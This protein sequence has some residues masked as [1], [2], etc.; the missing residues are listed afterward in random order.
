MDA[1]VCGVEPFAWFDGLDGC[2]ATGALTTRVFAC[3]E[4][5]KPMT[6]IRVA[7][8]V[9]VNRIRASLGEGRAQQWIAGGGRLQ[10]E[11]ERGRERESREPRCAHVLDRSSWTS[12]VCPKDGCR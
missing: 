5:A 7:K 9:A 10:I 12:A 4:T 8:T 2:S 1:E 6:I 3:V 11:K